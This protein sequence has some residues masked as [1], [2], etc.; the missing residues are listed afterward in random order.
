MISIPWTIPLW[1]I[2]R[3]ESTEMCPSRV[4]HTSMDAD[5]TVAHETKAVL[6]SDEMYLVMYAFSMPLTVQG[7]Q[8]NPLDKC[9]M[10][11]GDISALSI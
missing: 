11:I 5:V 3:I 6:T 10:P 7:N 1:A 9:A 2:F 4:C 8:Y